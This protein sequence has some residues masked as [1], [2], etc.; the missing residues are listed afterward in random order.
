MTIN[1]LS[2]NTTKGPYF[3]SSSVYSDEKIPSSFTSE[4]E[5]EIP[6]IV[7]SARTNVSPSDVTT[8][9][10]LEFSSVLS[11]LMPS[12]FHSGELTVLQSTSPPIMVYF[13]PSKGSYFIPSE[14][15]SVMTNFPPGFSNLMP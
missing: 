4:E 6:S 8:G 12:H 13:N 9:N 1:S 15:D 14:F 5:S 2:F 3:I 7:L 10:I 11:T